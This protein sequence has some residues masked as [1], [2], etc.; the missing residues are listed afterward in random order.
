MRPPRLL[1]SVQADVYPRNR[2]ELS[3]LIDGSIGELSPFDQAFGYYAHGVGEETA[4]LPS[5]WKD[6]LIRVSSGNAS[7]LCLE[8]NDLALSKLVAGR[9]KDIELVAAAARSRLIDRET[10]LARLPTIEIEPELRDIVCAR[11]H[12]AF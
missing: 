9:E 8:V 6:R 1:V 7:G 11:I 4:K 12:A 2:P 5:G 10:L 3:D